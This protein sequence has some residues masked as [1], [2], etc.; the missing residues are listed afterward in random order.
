[1]ASSKLYIEQKSESMIRGELRR[2]THDIDANLRG[3][4]IVDYDMYKESKFRNDLLFIAAV[5]LAFLLG[6]LMGWY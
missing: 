3:C 5:L 4:R 2:K 6:I 1:M